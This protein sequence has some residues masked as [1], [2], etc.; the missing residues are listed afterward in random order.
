MFR[1][2]NSSTFWTCIKEWDFCSEY[3]GTIDADYRGNWYH[4][5]NH[6]KNVFTVNNGDRIAQMVFVPIVKVK[7]N[8]VDE[9]N[10]THRGEGG[11]G[12]TGVEN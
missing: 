2:T 9:L 8:K 12:S 3:S 11:F 10:E 4:K 1:S 6:S 7:F 5:I